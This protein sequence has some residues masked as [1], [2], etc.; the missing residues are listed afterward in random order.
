MSLEDSIRA[1]LR[2]EMQRV[3][4]EELRA[5][6][7]DVRAADSAGEQYLSVFKAAAVAG[8]HPDTIRAWVKSGRLPEHRAGRELRIRYDEL[9]RFLDGDEGEKNRPTADE[10]AA[11]ILARKRLG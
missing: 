3:L 7:A 1:V 4:R 9:R 10:E 6:L 2:E 5:A 8:V 11:T